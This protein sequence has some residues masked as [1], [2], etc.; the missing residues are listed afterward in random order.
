MWKTSELH[1]EFFYKRKSV[2]FIKDSCRLLKAYFFGEGRDVTLTK[3]DRI[4]NDN[5]DLIKQYDMRINWMR[6][7]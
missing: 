7:I 1:P 4:W 5:I 3:V 2:L 6:F